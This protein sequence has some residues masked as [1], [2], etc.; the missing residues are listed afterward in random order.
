MCCEGYKTAG[1]LDV[2]ISGDDE[3]VIWFDRI[4]PTGRDTNSARAI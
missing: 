3:Q 1:T 2:T 4:E